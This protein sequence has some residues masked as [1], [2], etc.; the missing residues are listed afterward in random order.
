MTV[1]LLFSKPTKA[2]RLSRIEYAKLKRRVHDADD[3][4]CRCCSRIRPLTMHHMQRRSKG[5][6]DTLE[7]CLSLCLDCHQAET[8]H[9]VEIAWIDVAQRTVSVIW[10]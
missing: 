6:L 7:N 3:W 10:R 5:C 1:P 8:E 4:H 2:I 9:R